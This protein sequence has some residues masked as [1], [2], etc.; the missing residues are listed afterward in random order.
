MKI[1]ALLA[2]SQPLVEVVYWLSRY[3]DAAIRDYGDL[4][5]CYGC[6]PIA[7]SLIAYIIAHGIDRRRRSAADRVVIF[8]LPSDRKR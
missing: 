6:V 4:I 5:F 2:S 3:I 1:A 7:Y 8:I